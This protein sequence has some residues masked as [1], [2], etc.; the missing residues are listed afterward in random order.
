[1]LS[2]NLFESIIKTLNLRMQSNEVSLKACRVLKKASLMNAPKFWQKAQKSWNSANLNLIG[3]SRFKASK[4]L[5][6]RIAIKQL[7]SFKKLTFKIRW[8]FLRTKKSIGRKASTLM[9]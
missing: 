3:W 7:P 5:L 8:K 2:S 6:S 9:I 1:M 4:S